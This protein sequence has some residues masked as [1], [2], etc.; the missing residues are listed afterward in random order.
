MPAR[1]VTAMFAAYGY[2]SLSSACTRSATA[3]ITV[4]PTARAGVGAQKAFALDTGL[5]ARPL[6]S[7]PNQGLPAQ[8]AVSAPA[9]Q[10]EHMPHLSALRQANSVRHKLQS[11]ARGVITHSQ[12]SCPLCAA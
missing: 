3:V 4:S 10:Y 1:A 9:R 11:S 2:L 6:G 5:Y 8:W 7:E 12:H